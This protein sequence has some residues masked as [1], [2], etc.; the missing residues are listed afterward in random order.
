MLSLCSDVLR[1]SCEP[2]TSSDSRSR[3][4]IRA[5]QPTHYCNIQLYWIN[6]T[7]CCLYRHILII[8]QIWWFIK[9]R[10]YWKY[11][12]YWSPILGN[13]LTSFRKNWGIFDVL[14][15]MP[16]KSY[17]FDDT[18]LHLLMLNYELRC[19]TSHRVTINI[20]TTSAYLTR[21]RLCP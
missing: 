15:M 17:P 7:L 1:N 13:D 21:F 4:T 20:C 6:L 11:R 18:V 16:T 5:I 12:N 8:L 19:K 9:C 3:S 2:T 10:T 14:I